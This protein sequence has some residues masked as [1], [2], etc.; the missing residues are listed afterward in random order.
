L[1]KAK[2][3]KKTLGLQKSGESHKKWKKKRLGLK[4]KKELEKRRGNQANLGETYK[5]LN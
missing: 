2:K 3:K 5:K 4:K 1:N